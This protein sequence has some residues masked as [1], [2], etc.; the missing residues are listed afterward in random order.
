MS[1]NIGRL[2]KQASNQL[3]RRFDEFAQ[4]YDLTGVQMSII[5]YLGRHRAEPVLQ[6]DI[7]LE[8]AIQRSTTTLILQRMEKKQ[9]LTRQV[10]PNDARQKTIRL[11]DKALQLESVVRGYIDQQEQQLRTDFSATELRIFTKM[12]HYYL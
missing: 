8:F 1:E 9:L 6:R 2:L 7:E 4:Q 5:D 10:A 11:T 12:L 3:S